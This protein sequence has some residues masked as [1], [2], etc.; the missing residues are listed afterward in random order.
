[1][2]KIL[3]TLSLFIAVAIATVSCSSDDEIT[4]PSTLATITDFS[5]EIEGVI[6]DDITYDLGTNINVTVPYGTDLTVVV[7]NI[8]LSENATVSPASGTEI[9]FVDGEPKTFTVTAEDGVTTKEYI[10]TVQVS[11]DITSSRGTKLKTYSIADL[12]GETSTTT[13]V[14]NENG[15]VSEYT[16]EVDDWGTLVTTVYTLVYND[17]NQVVEKTAEGQS[18]VY[19]YDGDKIIKAELTDD[20]TLTYTY[21]YTYTDAGTLASEERIDHSD[22]DS[23]TEIT[24][25]IENGNVVLENRYG[26]DYTATYEDKNNPF[27]G[28][29]PTAFAAINI[30]IQSVNANNPITGTLADD[31]VTY[32]YNADNYPLSA[33]YTYFDGFATVE[34]TYNY[35]SE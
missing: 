29:Y 9:T 27:I 1:M 24:F 30:G 12:Y 22:N 8:S 11:T 32:E 15:F 7:P 18:T 34:K 3:S 6:A 35:Y 14:Y 4:P 25:T 28:M 5:I 2:K 17:N 13:Y 20:G 23:V 31:T 26:S 19:T 16:K 10:V 33:S 21:N